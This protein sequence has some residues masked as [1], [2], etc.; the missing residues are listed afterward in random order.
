MKNSATIQWGV[1]VGALFVLVALYGAFLFDTDGAALGLTLLGISAES[2]LAATFRVIGDLIWL[3]GL[4]AG[5]LATVAIVNLFREEHMRGTAIGTYLSARKL[6]KSVDKI[7]VNPTWAP[8]MQYAN[9]VMA[10]IGMGSGFWF[11]GTLWL[12]SLVATHMQHA[13][14]RDIVMELDE[15]AVER[16]LSAVRELADP[17][18]LA[19][20]DAL[21]IE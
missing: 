5:V 1:F 9:G 18:V 20:L 15:L 6:G 21:D 12:V 11:T 17:V 3:V 13:K 7:Y 2:G 19:A 4:A 10:L 14:L 8:T 16:G